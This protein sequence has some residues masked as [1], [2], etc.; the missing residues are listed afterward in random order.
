MPM[1]TPPLAVPSNFVCFHDT[2]LFFQ[3]EPGLFLHDGPH[4]VAQ[5]QHISTGRAAQVHHEAAVLFADGRAAVAEA[6]Q[7]ALVDEGRR[8]R[9]R[10]AL[11]G[12]AG[13]GT[14]SPMR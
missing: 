2:N 7:A 4:L 12:A 11:E 10:R 14:V 1:T 5:G 9:A 6:P 13:A 8:K 3:V